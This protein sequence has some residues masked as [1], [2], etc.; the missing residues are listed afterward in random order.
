EALGGRL[1]PFAHTTAPPRER[2]AAADAGGAY[3]L[4]RHG[5]AAALFTVSAGARFAAGSDGRPHEEPVPPPVL[6]LCWVPDG[7]G[8]AAAVDDAFERLGGGPLAEVVE[9]SDYRGL[10]AGRAG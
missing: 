5:G 4:L 9:A 2:V 10:K 3:P 6:D 1:R 7:E 8:A